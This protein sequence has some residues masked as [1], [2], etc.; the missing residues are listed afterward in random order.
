[1]TINKAAV[2]FET[3]QPKHSKAVV[4]PFPFEAI[5]TSWMTKA[6]KKYFEVLQHPENRDKKYDELS[7]LAGY[8]SYLPWYQAIKDE[9]FVEFL[10]NIGVKVRHIGDD[11]PPHHEVEYI[12]DPKERE[13][14]L[15]GDDWD[16]RRLIKD[17]PK[18]F[19]PKDFIT[20]FSK[21]ENIHLRQATKRHS[22]H[23]LGNWEARSFRN[24]L[25]FILPFFN[26]LHAKY[27]NIKSFQE[28]ERQ[29]HIEKVLPQIQSLSNNQAIRAIRGMRAMFQYMYSNKW[30]DGPKTDTLLI[31]YDIPKKAE[32]LPR[33]IPPHLKIRLDDYLENT[34]IP[35]L[36]DGEETPIVSPN[37]W[38]FII[39]LRHTGRRLEDMAHLIADSSDIDCLKYDLDGDPQL[40][41]DHR[42]AK[43][44]KDL[45]VPLAH[46]KDSEGKNIIERAILRQKQR[47]KDLPPVKSD[48]R[49]YLFREIVD[50]DKQGNR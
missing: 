32:T 5:D 26:I 16:M 28:L 35:L 9:R 39:I 8:K 33:P 7:T 22:I 2:P 21:I 37:Y 34:I 27:P 45:V 30:S 29:E 18:H 20:K 44:K 14:Y 6:Q 10:E 48:N 38:D 40:F 13:E 17:Y 50:Y 31:S 4:S 25:L 1:M 49:K 3:N 12:K 36:K 47:V 23:M 46:L 15:K 43:I 41:L 19:H 24:N 42:I 11:Y